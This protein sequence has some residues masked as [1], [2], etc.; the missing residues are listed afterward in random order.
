MILRTLFCLLSSLTLLSTNP[1]FKGEKV[2][3]N[4][5]EDWVHTRSIECQTKTRD[6]RHKSCD[7]L[8]HY[9]ENHECEN[10]VDFKELKTLRRCRKL[11]TCHPRD[12]KCNCLHNFCAM[13]SRCY[14]LWKSVL[15]MKYVDYLLDWMANCNTFEGTNNSD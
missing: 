8:Q 15:S 10:Y 2:Q 14:V 3:T 1:I 5:I 9:S 7:C 11:A 12:T 4:N 6:I 13:R